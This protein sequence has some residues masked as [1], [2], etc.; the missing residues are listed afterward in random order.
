[1]RAFPAPAEVEAYLHRHI[2]LSAG[3]GVRVVSADAGA[4]VLAAPLEPNINHRSTVFGGSVSAVTILA[5][6]AW[7]HFS[8]RSAGQTS[9]LVIQRNTVEYLAP[10]VGA[11]EVRC[12]GLPPAQLERFL[13]MLERHGKARA[14]VTAELTCVGKKAASFRGEYVAVR[15]G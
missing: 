9:R 1:M 3:M 10:V 13:R 15:S 5:A 2:P 12:P 7:L 6:W 8:L 14:V 4:V 11:F